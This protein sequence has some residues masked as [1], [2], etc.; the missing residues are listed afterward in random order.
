MRV[1]VV[2]AGAIGGYFGGRLQQA[3]RDVTFL[4]RPR[5]EAELAKA[6]LIIKSPRG[7]VTLR[8]PATI[9][10]ENIRHPFDL[11]LL[12]CK[13]YDLAGAMDSFAAA[14]G[15]ASVVLPL[16]NGMQHLEMLD[17]RFGTSKILG[18]QCVIAATLDAQRVVVHLNDTHKLTFGERDGL[19]SD[20]I[21]NVA[22]TLGDAGFD[23][24]LSENIVQEMWE[25]WVLL[26]AL[27][28]AT[29]LMRAPIGD[30]VASPGGEE[31]IR[32]LLEECR[33][34]ADEAGHLPR[35]AFLEQ[36]RAALTTAGSPLTASMLR[37][38][39]ANAP[40]EADHIVGD[41][42]RRRC[43]NRGKVSILATAYTHLKAY[44]T[45]RA[46]APTSP[47]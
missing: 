1:L 39:E 40:V 44:E 33:V 19:I 14:L 35:A 28:S 6:G 4:V 21:R 30:I 24:T 36:A 13:A 45:R 46:R 9:L 25:K 16:L 23:A 3:G 18:G 47:A 41:L 11:V 31:M 5:R 12:S 10:S 42:L 2:G 20:R 17:E 32:L 7:D 27:A 43:S 22:S 15:P 26:A 29:C 8:K 37:D 38:V 34:I